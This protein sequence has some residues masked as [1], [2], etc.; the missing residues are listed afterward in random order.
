LDR[1]RNMRPRGLDEEIGR[2]LEPMVAHGSRMSWAGILRPGDEFPRAAKSQLAVMTSKSGAELRRYFGQWSVKYRRFTTNLS[3]S[4]IRVRALASGEKLGRGIQCILHWV[5]RKDMVSSGRGSVCYGDGWPR[6]LWEAFASELDRLP[7]GTVAERLHH[8]LDSDSQQE[9]E[10]VSLWRKRVKV[11]SL[12]RSGKQTDLDSYWLPVPA[13][14]EVVGGA[15]ATTTHCVVS[16]SPGAPFYE[17]LSEAL[18]SGEAKVRNPDYHT[19]AKYYLEC[20]LGKLHGVRLDSPGDYVEDAEY[21]ARPEVKEL[22]ASFTR[23]EQERIQDER[24]GLC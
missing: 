24:F 5:A 4:R 16:W 15:T 2:G 8:F 1:K 23:L 3:T 17:S 19:Q 20:V 12:V 9:N 14:L 10:W 11:G 6:G 22:L 13:T 21:A 7:A 18:S